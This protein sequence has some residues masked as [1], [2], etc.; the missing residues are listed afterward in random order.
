MKQNKFLTGFLIVVLLGAGVLGFLLFQA[1]GKYNEA[2]DTYTTKAGE[3][4][5]LQGGKPYPDEANYK[6]M[7]DL[8]KAHQGA[9]NGLQAELAAAEIPVKAMRPAEFQ[10]KLKSTL[11]RI[12]AAAAQQNVGLPK[13]KTFAL[14]RPRLRQLSDRSA[15]GGD[16]RSA[17][18]HA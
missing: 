8:Q 3:L 6:K 16:C 13:D 1:K 10:D 14:V 4:T 15:Q 7:L 9:I 2:Y 11:D 17:R 18:A 12:R 5:T